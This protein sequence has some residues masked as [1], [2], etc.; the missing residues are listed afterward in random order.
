M[1]IA[2]FIGILFFFHGLGNAFDGAG[3]AFWLISF[4]VLLFA[5][6]FIETGGLSLLIPKSIWDKLPDEEDY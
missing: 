4:G 3:D 6:S 1:L 2:T 5:F